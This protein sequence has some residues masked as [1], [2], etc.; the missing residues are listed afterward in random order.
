MVHSP[1]VVAANRVKFDTSKGFPAVVPTTPGGG[2]ASEDE[3]QEVRREGWANAL[4]WIAEDE[5]VVGGPGNRVVRSFVTW[6]V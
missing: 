6:I 4:G 3:R 2:W 1:S 5:L